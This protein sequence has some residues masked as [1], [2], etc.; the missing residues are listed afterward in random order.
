MPVSFCFVE[1]LGTARQGWEG[2]KRIARQ[3]SKC[4]ARLTWAVLGWIGLSNAGLDPAGLTWA[5][6]DWIGLDSPG[7]GK[8]GFDWAEQGLAGPGWIDLARMGWADLGRVGLGL[9]GLNNV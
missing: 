1:S 9:I 8:A 7:P 6:L 3:G 4:S 2:G 5:G